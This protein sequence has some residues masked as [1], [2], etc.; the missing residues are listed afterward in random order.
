MTV[1]SLLTQEAVADEVFTAHG[2]SVVGLAPTS[3]RAR[4]GAWTLGLVFRRKPPGDSPYTLA[5]D[6]IRRRL[7][8]EKETV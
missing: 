1:G 2:Q 6:E 8:G 4:G 3:S 5:A 7:W